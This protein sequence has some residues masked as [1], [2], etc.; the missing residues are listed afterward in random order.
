MV[1][2]YRKDGYRQRRRVHVRMDETIVEALD[3]LA[4]SLSLS[5]AYVC[6]LILCIAVTEGGEWLTKA[7]H[8]RVANS[9]AKRLSQWGG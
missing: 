7:I 1:R 5:R 9:M 3:D 2:P 4:G 8:R 6:D